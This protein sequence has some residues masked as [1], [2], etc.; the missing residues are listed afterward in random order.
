MINISRPNWLYLEKSNGTPFGDLVAM[1]SEISEDSW[2]T[3]WETDLEHEIWELINTDSKI[4]K[5]YGW[6]EVEISQENANLMLN[7]AKQLNGWPADTDDEIGPELISMEKW[8]IKHKNW[9]NSR[10]QS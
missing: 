2:A 7:L 1:L 4:R 3:A 6:N 10:T 8:L 9:K 5:T